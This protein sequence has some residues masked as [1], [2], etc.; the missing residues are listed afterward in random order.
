MAEITDVKVDQFL[1]V[2]YHSGG[3]RDGNGERVSRK[4]LTALAPCGGTG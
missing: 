4:P 2:S 3:W 1:V